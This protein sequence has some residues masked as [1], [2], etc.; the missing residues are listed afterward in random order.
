MQRPLFGS[1]KRPLPWILGLLGVGVLAV[2]GLTY[3]L[4]Q[5][6]GAPSDLEKY[7][8][9]ATQETL[10]VEIEANGVVQPVQT[11]NISPKTPGRIVG[12]FVEQGDRVQQGQRLAVM[13][14]QEAF[15]DG[16]QSQARLQE[17]IARFRE[18]EMKIPTEL[19]QLQAEVNQAKTRIAQARSQLQRS[20]ARLKEVQTRIPGDIDQLAAQARASES[21]LKLAQSRVKR[22]QSLLEEGAI[23]QDRFDELLNDFYTAQADLA[24]ALQRLEQAKTTAFPEVGQIQQEIQQ[25][26]GAILETEQALK[27]QEAA[28]QRRAATAK[29][30]LASLKASAEA[31]QAQ[32]E[33]SKIQYRD[34]YIVAP[35]PG[36]VTQR[37]ASVGA[38]VTPT[39]TASTTAS[40]TSTSILSIARGL[41]VVAKVPEVD[42]GALRVGQPVIIQADAYPNQSFQGKVTRVAPEAIVE[43]NVTS[44]EVVVALVTGQDKL[45]SKMNVDVT[46]QGEPLNSAVTVP[47]VAIVTQNGETGVM[48]PDEENNPQFA[49]V[50]VG[51]VLDSK[52][53]IL[54]GLEPGERVFIDLPEAARKKMEAE[55]KP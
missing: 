51:L 20:Q 42:V 47:T 13:E 10:T 5:S 50:T 33:R 40:A 36:I 38:F 23:S 49:P 45:R 22:N 44:F 16:M 46:F 15:A 54:S 32:L 52:T 3:R 19:N 1:P 17:A 7:T 9:A 27:A 4:V 25:N 18:A 37:F 11:V 8:V 55:E 21:R 34:T 30:E 12:L 28:L 24:A 31:A 14:N 6:S 35:F 39:T 29:A 26:Q 48:T 41:E 53:Q 43:N 2:G